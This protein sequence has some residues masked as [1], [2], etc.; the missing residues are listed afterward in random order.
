MWLVM[1]TKNAQASLAKH[2]TNHSR[3]NTLIIDDFGV[4]DVTVWDTRR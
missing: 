2:L 4:G 1:S 3:V